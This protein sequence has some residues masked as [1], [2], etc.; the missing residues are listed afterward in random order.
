MRRIRLAFLAIAGLLGASWA[1]SQTITTY[2]GLCDA[3][4]AV[5]L[6]A[7]HFA[8]A[9]DEHNTLQIYRRGAPKPV[10]ALKLD[11]FLE[12][13]K[14]SDLEGAATLAGVTYWI[15]SHGR[16]ADGKVRKDRHRLFATEVVPGL[17]G[18]TLRTI[19]EV[20]RTLLKELTHAAALK[21][22][23]LEAASRR[24]PEAPGGLNIEGLA[25]TPDG[26]LLI[27]FRNPIPAGGALVV[28]IENPRALLAG[29]PARFGTPIELPLG[30]RG[31]RSIELVGSQYLVVAGPPADD[32]SFALYRWSGKAGDK[33]QPLAVDLQTLHP[34]ALFEIPGTA[35][36][37]VLSDD[38]GVRVGGVACK[39]LPR[40]RRS[41]R[42]IIVP[43]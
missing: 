39:D 8:V 16:N 29:K 40:G 2:E 21:P 20:H 10:G 34:E 22:Y 27:G 13:E 3:S 17:P 31:I 7:D 41:F 9:D 14:E 23:A 6:D 36:V 35:S 37:Q 33:P 5:A 28:P 43:L 19:G 32:G 30:E 38:G 24:A 12:T 15:A 1:A 42:S 11:R 4:A 18:P 26:R 25:A